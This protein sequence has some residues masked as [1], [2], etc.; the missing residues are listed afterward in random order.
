VDVNWGLDASFTVLVTGPDD[1]LITVDV[2]WDLD[3]SFT[4]LVIGAVDE[5]VTADVN[6]GLDATVDL[7]VT[8]AIIA[9]AFTPGL[10]TD[11][12]VGLACAVFAG[13][14]F[15]GSIVSQLYIIKLII[16]IGMEIN[17]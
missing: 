3:A 16:Q 1:E 12:A 2:N 9:D 5:L 7:F 13:A 17:K 14:D 6:W 4:V 8:G 15:I 10:A 11:L